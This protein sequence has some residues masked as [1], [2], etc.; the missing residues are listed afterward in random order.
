M[1]NKLLI[2]IDQDH[3]FDARAVDAAVTSLSDWNVD[4]LGPG[5]GAIQQYLCTQGNCELMLRISD[6]VQTVTIDGHPDASRATLALLLET[7]CPNRLRMTDM[8]FNFD[9]KLGD[10]A[11]AEELL[12]AISS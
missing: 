2:Y 12:A 4:R 5:I 7:A 10:Y 3:A 1:S 8:G 9:L 6:D 11:S